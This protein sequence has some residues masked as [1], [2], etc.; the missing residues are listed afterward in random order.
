MNRDFVNHVP[1]AQTLEAFFSFFIFKSNRQAG[2][3]PWIPRALPGASLVR[4]HSV[5]EIY[6]VW[7]LLL[8]PEKA[9]SEFGR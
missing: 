7:R 9:R 5:T 4:H 3:Q 8:S 2:T 6:V 1:L